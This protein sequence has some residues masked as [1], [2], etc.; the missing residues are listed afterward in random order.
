MLGYLQ[1]SMRL[2]GEQNILHYFNPVSF[3]NQGAAAVS[4][5]VEL[6]CASIRAQFSFKYL[7][8]KLG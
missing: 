3:N 6:P 4:E 5:C 8:K 1:S 7:W 2:L